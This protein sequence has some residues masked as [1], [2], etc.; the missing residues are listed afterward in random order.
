MGLNRSP[1]VNVFS[2]KILASVAGGARARGERGWER[3]WE[4]ILAHSSAYLQYSKAIGSVAG[5]IGSV[6]GSVASRR[7]VSRE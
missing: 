6:A 5:S 7:V 2:S 4:R 3:G 1:L